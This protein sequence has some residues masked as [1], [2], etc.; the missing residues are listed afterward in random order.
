MY[1]S[2]EAQGRIRG[3]RFVS[4]FAGEQFALPEAVEGLRAVRRATAKGAVVVLSAADPLNL[5]GILLPGERLSPFSG[6]GVVLRDGTVQDVGP[7]GAL[8]RRLSWVG[9][10]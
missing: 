7:L 6:L 5:V 1:R 8:L 9:P 2:W 10:A 4:G 3:G